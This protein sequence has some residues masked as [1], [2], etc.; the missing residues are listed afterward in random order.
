M[1]SRTA[2]KSLFDA[3]EYESEVEKRFARDLD[4]N[5]N[6][7]L[8]VKLPVLVQD[9]HAHRCLQSRLGLRHGA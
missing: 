9:R 8:F 1:R 7:K 4:S 2:R 5:E 3:V 6:V